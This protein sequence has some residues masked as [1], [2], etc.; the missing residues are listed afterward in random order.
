[1]S[2]FIP[3]EL[4]KSICTE[5]TRKEHDKNEPPNRSPNISPHKIPYQILYVS[6]KRDFQCPRDL[7]VAEM[8]YFS[9]YLSTDAQRWEE[10]DISVHC[11]VQIFNWLMKYVKRNSMETMGMVMPKLG[12]VLSIL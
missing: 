9:E 4:V 5:K 11:D 6:V 8:R 10:V 7:L 2:K 3:C 12:E 1:M